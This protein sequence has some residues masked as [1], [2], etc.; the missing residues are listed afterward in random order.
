M[1]G[2]EPDSIEA[3]VALA[4]HPLWLAAA[5]E[6]CKLAR[7]VF[8]ADGM[9]TVELG[10]RLFPGDVNGFAGVGKARR[11]VKEE[12]LPPEQQGLWPC[13]LNALSSSFCLRI[14]QD[15]YL[16]EQRFERGEEVS[17]FQKICE[18]PFT[19]TVL[20]YRLDREIISAEL[21]RAALEVEIERIRTAAPEL[22]L[23]VR[24]A[25]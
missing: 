2:Q 12:R 3:A 25:G 7:A 11:E 10:L 9:T 21:S 5:T 20:D 16:Y 17:P 13:L 6:G 4:S 19:K 24:F 8:R 23:T 22:D 18:T 14:Y 1:L 15:G